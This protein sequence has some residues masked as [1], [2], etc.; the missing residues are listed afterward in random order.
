MEDNTQKISEKILGPS[1]E[2]SKISDEDL[3]LAVPTG[4]QDVFNEL[5]LRKMEKRISDTK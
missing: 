5:L 3:L 2:L 4:D 1:P